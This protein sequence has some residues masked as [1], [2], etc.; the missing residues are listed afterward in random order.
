MCIYKSF[1]GPY[2]NQKAV[3]T[4]QENIWDTYVMHI[5]KGKG[6]MWNIERFCSS[7]KAH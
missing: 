2:Y 3:K 7:W 4:I 6:L 5:V 1:F